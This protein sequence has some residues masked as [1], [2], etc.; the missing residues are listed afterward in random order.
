MKYLLGSKKEFDSFLNSI[1]KKDKIGIITH[2]DADGISSAVFLRKIIE[3]KG[4][5]VS[6]VEFSDYAEGAIASAFDRI[7]PK[8]L[9]ITD[10][11]ADDN[12]DFQYVR[13]KA[14]VFLIDHHPLNENIKDTK[15]II[16]TEKIFCSTHCLYNLAEGYLDRKFLKDM[17]WLVCAA[18]IMDFC[19]NRE[20]TFNFIKL[21][22]PEVK[23]DLS[24]FDSVPGKMGGKINSALIYYN[25]NFRKVY[26]L[27]LNSK[28]DK[29]SEAA[30]IIDEEIKLWIGKFKK[31]AEVFPSKGLHF[32]Y[33]NPKHNIA[34]TVATMVS[35]NIDG[36]SV[37]FA[38]DYGKGKNFIKT[39]AR[40]Q[41]GRVDLRMVLK[42][43]VEG[44]ENATA[45]GHPKAS[46]SIFPKKYFGEF[47]KR[48]LENL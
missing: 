2:T 26:D 7:G 23:M 21:K 29:L 35:E 48:L 30:F 1:S 24:I 13:E 14:D 6:S 41:S 36:E 4:L 37:I 38:S 39:S 34:S 42:K 17:E 18:M 19:W 3:S 28:M 33:G 25:P 10:L 22:Y 40:N 15:N 8:K 20:D 5:K 9:F 16:K 43:C 45:G 44:F 31:E 46:S 11:N 32:Y 12:K 47:K 27:I